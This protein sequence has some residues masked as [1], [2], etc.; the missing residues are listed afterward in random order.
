MSRV[1]REEFERLYIEEKKPYK[2]I[3]KHFGISRS[4][5]GYYVNKYDLPK[6]Q[7]RVTLYSHITKEILEELYLMKKKTSYEISE[8]F[9][10]SQPLITYRLSKFKIP[11][12]RIGPTKYWKSV[13]NTR[14]ISG[15]ATD[16]ELGLIV[17]LIEGEGSLGLNIRGRGFTPYIQIANKNKEIHEEA[18]KIMGGIINGV[19]LNICSLQTVQKTLQKLVPYLFSTKGKIAKLL[20]KYCDL[21]STH[22]YDPYTDEE[23]EIWKTIRVLN[24]GNKKKG[25]RKDG[26]LEKYILRRQ[27]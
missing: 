8:I 4:L 15:K 27:A 12:R 18:Q 7:Y 10:C 16:Y 19:N 14:I 22:P 23:I 24:Q 1:L 13:E 20:L 26:L 6:R 17:G 11:I 21:R 5:V 25:K 3:A 9:G 2:E